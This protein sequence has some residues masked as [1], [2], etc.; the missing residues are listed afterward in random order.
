[1]SS[2]NEKPCGFHGFNLKMHAAMV[3]YYESYILSAIISAY[4]EHNKYHQLPLPILQSFSRDWFGASDI[5]LA[6]ALLQGT[7]I[8]YKL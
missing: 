7:Y 6:F 1:M 3:L 8:V 4:I 5:I 2:S